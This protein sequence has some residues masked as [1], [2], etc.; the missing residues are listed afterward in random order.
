MIPRK[1]K[2]EDRNKKNP[3]KGKFHLFLRREK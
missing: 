3:K 2:E 1:K